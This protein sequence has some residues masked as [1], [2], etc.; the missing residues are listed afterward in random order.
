MGYTDWNPSHTITGDDRAWGWGQSCAQRSANGYNSGMGLIFR[1]TALI[2]PMPA[3]VDATSR[4]RIETASSNNGN[5]ASGSS[6]DVRGNITA[7]ASNA[8]GCNPLLPGMLSVSSL[9]MIL[10]VLLI[11]P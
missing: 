4:V 1:Q 10:S 7:T 11:L 6:D 9:C 3:K 2:T 5:A 8:N